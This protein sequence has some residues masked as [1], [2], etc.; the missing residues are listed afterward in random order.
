MFNICLVDASVP[1]MRKAS[2]LFDCEEAP[3]QVDLKEGE[4]VEV[5]SG[6]DGSKWTTVQKKDGTTGLVPS[7][8]LGM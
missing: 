5:T 7:K 1:E 8:F 4:V 2:C 3:G 6:E